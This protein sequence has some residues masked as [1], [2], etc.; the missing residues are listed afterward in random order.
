[1]RLDR[2]AKV[3]GELRTELTELRADVALYRDLVALLLDSHKKTEEKVEGVAASARMLMATSDDL[4][5]LLTRVEHLQPKLK[6]A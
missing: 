4:R 1:M 2:A 3:V 6:V 5:S